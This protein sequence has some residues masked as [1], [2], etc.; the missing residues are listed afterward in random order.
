MKLLKER[1]VE[2]GH[3]ISD[4]ALCVDSF[5][6]HQVDAE[7]MNEIGK[8]FHKLFV[9]EGVTKVVT[10]EASGIGVAIMAALHLGVPMVFAKKQKPLTM[11]EA[12]TAEVYSF[13]KKKFYNISISKRFVS[14]EDRILL[15]DDFLA[16]GEAAEGLISIIEDQAQASVAGI[17]IVIEKGFQDGGKKLREKGYRIESLAVVESLDHGKVIFS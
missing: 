10:I 1:I 4:S 9:N 15:I 13:T 8:E 3:V 14:P 7:L 5:L 16:T 12:Y 17:G 2:D 11:A 6:N